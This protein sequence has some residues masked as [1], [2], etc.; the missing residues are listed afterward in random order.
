MAVNIMYS[1][2]SKQIN[3]ATEDH[4]A[5]SKGIG[6]VPILTINGNNWTLLI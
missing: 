3:C 4:T 6:T 1:C 5:E 2:I